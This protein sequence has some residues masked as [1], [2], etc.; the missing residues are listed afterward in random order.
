MNDLNIVEDDPIL[1]LLFSE[2]YMGYYEEREKQRKREPRGHRGL[3][4]TCGSKETLSFIF[5]HKRRT[6][7]K[8]QLYRASPIILTCVGAIGVIA[9]AV[10][11]ANAT[12]KAKSHCTKLYLEKRSCLD[13]EPKPI[14]YVK[15]A[16]HCY[17]PAAAVGLAT[18]ACIFGANALNK[19][20]QAAITSAYILLDSAYREYRTKANQLF[21]ENADTQIRDSLTK[22]KYVESNSPTGSD[23]LIFFEE[24][25]G[26]FFERTEEEVLLAEYHLNRNFILRGYAT[27]NEFY[28]FLNLPPV[29]GGDILG[30]GLYAGEAFYGYSWVDF[31]HRLVTMDDGMECRA[32]EFP[33][34]PTVDYLDY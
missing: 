32:I 14:E 25:Y 6:H 18:I 24:Y 29:K 23:K 15:V 21:G 10:M 30:W 28:E 13:D 19:H 9:T 11:A 31:N 27:L 4:S 12:I 3:V 8:H 16:W 34:L 5:S 26:K 33:F 2:V 22:D 1:I 20:Q 7:M 17:I